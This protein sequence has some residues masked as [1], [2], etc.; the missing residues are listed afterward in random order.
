MPPLRAPWRYLL[1]FALLGGATAR[2][3]EPG[4]TIEVEGERPKTSP[5]APAAA[6]TTIDTAQ[7]GGEVRSVAEML[8]AAPGVSVHALGGPGQAATL[9]LRGASA[10]QSVVLLDGI[11][12]QGPGGGAVDLPRFP[13]P[14]WS[15]WWSAGACSAHS[16]APERWAAR[17]SFSR[18][19]PG[20]L[21]RRSGAVRRLVRNGAAGARR[22]PACRQR[23]CGGRAPG[24]PDRRPV[25]VC[26]PAHPGDPRFSEVRV[27]ARKRRRDA[28]V[29]AV[30]PLPGPRRGTRPRSAPAGIGRAA[31]VAGTLLRAHAALPRAGPERRRRPAAARRGGRRRL[32]APRV[33]PPRSRRA[34]RRPGIRRLRRRRS[35]L[36][37]RRPALLEPGR[38]RRAGVSFG[39]ASSIHLR[40][41]GGADRIHGSGTGAHRRAVLSASIRDD[42]A[43]PPASPSTRRCGST[44]STATPA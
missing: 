10:D 38:R 31:R 44:A 11:P 8:L 4:E 22:R 32:G 21:E 1:P 23:E 15:G 18:G 14:C 12:L 28:R 36:P 7:F 30:S 6:G 2:A 27:H 19:R 43:L 20:E 26:P 17:S 42:V 5:Q 24:R 34:S 37:A 3:Q 35:R 33:G 16:S 41:A 40:L 29:G 25:R 9:S 39:E 13:P